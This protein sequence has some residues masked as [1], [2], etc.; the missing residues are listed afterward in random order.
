[1]GPIAGT[2][3]RTAQDVINYATKPSKSGKR[4]IKPIAQDVLQQTVP[5]VGNIVMNQLYPKKN[6]P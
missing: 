6:Q 3:V 2:G 5:G 1:M 4:N